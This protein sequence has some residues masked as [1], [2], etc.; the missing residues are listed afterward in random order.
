MI[1]KVNSD[2]DALLTCFQ[3]KPTVDLQKKVTVPKYARVNFSQ[4]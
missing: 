3:H 1:S 4:K 2:I